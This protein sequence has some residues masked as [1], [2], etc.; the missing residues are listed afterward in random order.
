[1]DLCSS[2]YRTAV[3]SC[4]QGNEPSASTKDRQFL[5]QMINH[6]LLKD[7]IPWS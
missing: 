5:D 4:T 2:D 1:M 3:G 7:L 6:W